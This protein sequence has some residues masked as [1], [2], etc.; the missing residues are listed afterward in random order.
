M[1][2]QLS[3]EGTGEGQHC[4]LWQGFGEGVKGTSGGAGGKG[5]RGDRL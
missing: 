3:P 2:L 5:G 4:D 1:R